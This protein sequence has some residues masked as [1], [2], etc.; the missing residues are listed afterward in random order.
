MKKLFSLILVLIVSAARAQTTVSDYFTSKAT[1]SN[2]VYD[3]GK[4]SAR[5]DYYNLKA[6][7]M[8]GAYAPRSITNVATTNTAWVASN[9]DNSTGTRGQ[10]NS[11]FLNISNAV[12]SLAPGGL[13]FIGPGTFQETFIRLNRTNSAGISLCG[14]GAGRT[15]IVGTTGY[16][17]TNYGPLVALGHSS[18]VTALSISNNMDSLPQQAAIGF[19]TSKQ[20]GVNVTNSVIRSVAMFGNSDCA[21][22]NDNSGALASSVLS[23][24]VITRAKWDS[25]FFNPLVDESLQTVR[26]CWFNVNQPDDYY[27]T[28]TNVWSGNVRAVVASAGQTMFESCIVEAT[29]GRNSYGVVTA[30]YSVQSMYSPTNWNTTFTATGTNRLATILDF[31]EGGEPKV[32]LQTWAVPAP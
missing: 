21:Y 18:V 11:P 1:M 8:R 29:G 32:T 27:S 31:Y 6:V 3:L 10:S 13:V 30:F 28:S 20:G 22:F 2:A 17:L 5:D 24:Y 19:D 4:L 7:I 15:F 26:Y 14:S 25:W 12:H 9:G 23:E 16:T